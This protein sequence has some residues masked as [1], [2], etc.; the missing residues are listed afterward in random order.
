M[1]F[2]MMKWNEVEDENEVC[3]DDDDDNDERFFDPLFPK[4][5]GDVDDE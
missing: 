2:M 3:V 1:K 5:C 4:E